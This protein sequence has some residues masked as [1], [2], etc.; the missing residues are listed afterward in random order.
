MVALLYFF[1]EVAQNLSEFVHENA[2]ENKFEI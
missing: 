1:Q 2:Q